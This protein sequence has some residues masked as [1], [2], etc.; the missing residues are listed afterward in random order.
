MDKEYVNIGSPA[1]RLAEECSELIK[2][3][4]KA[5]RFGYDSFNPN[6]YPCRSNLK[7]DWCDSKGSGGF[8]GHVCGKP[9]SNL[10]KIKNEFNDMLIAWGDFIKAL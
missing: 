5:E 9:K 1:I 4:M 2:A 7:E 3:I 8:M 6:D 10:D